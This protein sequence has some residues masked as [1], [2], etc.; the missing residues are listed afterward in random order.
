MI[1]LSNWPISLSTDTLLVGQDL[2]FFSTTFDG[3]KNWPDGFKKE[4]KSLSHL[5]FTNRTKLFYYEIGDIIIKTFTKCL[6]N[7]YMVRMGHTTMNFF[8]KIKYG[9]NELIEHSSIYRTNCCSIFNIICFSPIGFC[10]N[11]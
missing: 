10:I 8:F 4:L 5:N 1:F 7:Q 9:K 6:L 11:L 3:L 2:H